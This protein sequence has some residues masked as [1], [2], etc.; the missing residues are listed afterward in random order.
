MSFRLSGFAALLASASL[1]LSPLYAQEKTPA[2]PNAPVAKTASA[3]DS[4]SPGKYDKESVVY[5]KIATVANYNADGTGDKTLEVVERVQ[6]DG[7]VRQ[8]GL[9]TF[10]Y[11]SDN[12]KL[13]IDYV[14]VRKPNGTVVVT[15][16]DSV[17]DMPT[18][19]TRIAPLYSDQREVQIPVKSL[20]AGDT[21]EYKIHYT[22]RKASAP[23]EF[24]GAANFPDAAVVLD[25]SFTLTYPNGEYVQIL[26][27][28]YKPTV[29]EKNGRTIYVWHTS[30]LTPTAKLKPPT[31]DPNALPDIS[32]T[33]FKTWQQVGDWY[34]GLAKGREVVTP[35][36]QA[37]V[38]NLIQGKTT[39]K[40]K[41]RAIYH[42][43]STQVRYI[44]VDFGIGR[45]QPHTAETVFENQYGD[46]KD[47]HTLLSAMLKAAGYDAWPALIGTTMRLHTDLPAPSQFDHVITVVSLPKG[48]IWLDST[49]E[50]TPY[51]YLMP[52]IRDKEALV[53][54]TNGSPE[55]LRTPANAP[56][57]FEDVYT[58]TGQMDSN[59]TLTGH[60]TFQLRGD[61]E[62]AFREAFHTISRDHWQQAAQ[63]MSQRMGF[64][65]DVSNFDASLPEDTTTPFIFSFDYKQKKYADWDDR[66]ILPLT[67]PVEISGIG[68][69]KPTTPIQLGSPRKET[70]TSTIA[71][72]PDYTA[73]LPH[74]VSYTTDF[75][76]YTANYS[77]NGNKFVT[78]RELT[79]LKRQLPIDRADDYRKF[80][81]HVDD[82]ENQYIQLVASDA[83]VKPDTTPSNP[84]AIE[85]MQTAAANL[86][87]HNYVDAR[88]NLQQ[89]QQLNPRQPGL[90]SEFAY[91][92][93]MS[94]NLDQAIV[95]LR[96]EVTYHPES[97]QAWQQMWNIQYKLKRYDD[98]IQTLRDEL[99][100]LP[101]NP[102]AESQ[103]GYLLILRKKYAEAAKL[104][105]AAVK[106]VPD[107]REMHIQAGRAELL[108]GNKDAATANLKQALKGTTDPGTLNDA[109]YEMADFNF[110]LPEA[111][112]SIKQAVDKLNKQTAQI[113]LGNLSNDDLAHVN[114]LTAA[115]DT[116]GW[117]YFRE[118]QLPL[119]ESYV[120]AAWVTSQASEV[121]GHLA[122]IYEKEHKYQQA[123][124]TDALALAAATLT[125][126]PSGDDALTAL[127]KR[128]KAKG[129]H[130]PPGDAG[131]KLGK[132]RTYSVPKPSGAEGSAD[133]FVLLSPGKVDDV[134]FIHGDQQLRSAADSI[135]KVDFTGQFP[136][137]STAKLL[138]RGILFCSPVSSGCQFTLLLPQSVSLH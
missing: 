77:L 22:I 34:A 44:G 14:R 43:V 68:D 12:E 79:I 116:M 92:E 117:V 37:K 134:Q 106:Q 93:M 129:F 107:N 70:H 30:Q 112:S 32:Y 41:I 78:A 13:N 86:T 109:A 95:D 1:F 10:A 21:L 101:G 11:A 31:P 85:L 39:D 26:D 74:S 125:P 5:R 6:T 71:L 3:P 29:S 48:I 28:G 40:E 46:C 49:P 113:S 83:A 50:V 114:L 122:Q 36:I 115:W 27:S 64:G 100:A 65:G 84:E 80:I 62:V 67:M 105:E 18:Q 53:I 16:P 25:Q 51:R 128:M 42:F 20:S 82:D 4:A 69:D 9:L 98:A 56:Y 72:P 118:G 135:R 120:S 24:W 91:L 121:G 88:T 119:A 63:G 7:G 99:K 76:I 57:P 19:V 94:N 133:F 87:N 138:R 132:M 73:V 33:T 38:N 97:T 2:L 54:P 136:E 75:A 89:A 17:E 137:G 104:Y 123:V 103:L 59:G 58:S 66:R 8:A 96:K 110:E 90:W 60:L 47:K 124:N 127:M 102:D 55:L 15:P 35:D 126:D 61:V 111:E 81:K 52:Q 130:P 45:Y 108:A 23:N 131:Q